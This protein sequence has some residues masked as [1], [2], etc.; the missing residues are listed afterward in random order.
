MTLR[1]Y[2]AILGVAFTASG[3]DILRAYRAK[4]YERHPDR[5]PG[6]PRASADMQLLNEAIGVLRDA[7]KRHAYDTSLRAF[8]QCDCRAGDVEYAITLTPQQAAQGTTSTLTFHNAQGQ[9]YMVSIAV[10]AG[11]ETG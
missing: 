11:V 4:A 7:V 2:Y 8:V 5:N 1:D 6:D 9:P 3:E 10:P